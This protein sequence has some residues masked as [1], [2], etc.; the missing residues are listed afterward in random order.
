MRL[1][2]GEL[3]GRSPIKL[4]IGSIRKPLLK[5]IDDLGFQLFDQYESLLFLTAE[6]YYTKFLGENGVQYWNELSDTERQ[7]LNLFN[8]IEKHQ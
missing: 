4:S 3:I 7:S 5:D 6:I 2:Y 8:V 1:S